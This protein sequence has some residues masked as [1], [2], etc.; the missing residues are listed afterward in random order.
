MKVIAN[1]RWLVWGSALVVAILVTTGI[2]VAITSSKPAQAFT[3]ADNAWWVKD[4]V[5]AT[6]RITPS[7][8][9]Q[10]EG[11]SAASGVMSNALAIAGKPPYGNAVYKSLFEQLQCHLL[12]RLKTPYDLDTSRPTVAW[13]TEVNDFCNP[14]PPGS[15]TAPEQIESE[16]SPPVTAPPP[17]SP[18]PTAPPPTAPPVTAPSVTAPPPTSPP[19]T[20]PPPT[21]PPVT[22]SPENS[23]TVDA[24]SAFGTCSA[25]N[26]P[27]FCGGD[28][29]AQPDPNFVSGRGVD[30]PQGTQT[31]G[32]CWKDGGNVDAPATGENS[33]VWIET[34]LSP[35][36][37]MS[38]LYFAPGAANGL[39]EC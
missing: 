32:L 27:S 20:A 36:P 6:L 2:S 38:V 35:D 37:W 17:T 13:V 26:V 21:A 9:A 3:Y 33:P 11:I 7:A 22:A 8:W 34:T 29:H 19:P 15:T 10:V 28:A 24:T 31:T 1:R 30:Q 4:P 18:P 16:P 25:P 23:L 12:V 5:G 14:E 39:D